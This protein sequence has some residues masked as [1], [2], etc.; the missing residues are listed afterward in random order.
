MLLVCYR[1][2]PAIPAQHCQ[3]RSHSTSRQHGAAPAVAVPPAACTAVG[4]C[5]RSAGKTEQEGCSCGSAAARARLG[6]LSLPILS[7]APPLLIMQSVRSSLRL[8][9]AYAYLIPNSP[10]R[11]EQ[12]GR[13]AAGPP[14]WGAESARAKHGVWGAVQRRGSESGAWT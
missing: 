12:L 4:A 13:W 9:H 3:R 2:K 14:V 11:P 7:R 8:A 1:P 10:R 5:E 6:C